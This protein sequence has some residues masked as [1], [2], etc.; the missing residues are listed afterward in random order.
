MCLCD[1]CFFSPQ[2]AFFFPIH[3]TVFLSLEGLRVFFESWTKATKCLSYTNLHITICICSGFRRHWRA[4]QCTG[5]AAHTARPLLTL[6]PGP[7]HAWQMDAWHS[8]T[9]HYARLSVPY[10]SEQRL[11]WGTQASHLGH[12]S[13]KSHLLAEFHWVMMELSF[14]VSLWELSGFKWWLALLAK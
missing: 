4:E 3:V 2:V 6:S 1:L 10:L 9:A 11:L 8:A 5:V 12:I 13:R 7:K 14:M